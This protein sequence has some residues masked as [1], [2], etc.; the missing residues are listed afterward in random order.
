MVKN[1]RTVITSGVFDL[2][3]PGHI[4]LLKFAKKLAGK[5]GRLIVVIARDE[6][7]LRR[8]RRKPILSENDRLKIVNSIK[9][10]DKAVL[11][12][13]PMS[14]KKIIEKYRP[15]VVVFGYDQKSIMNAFQKEATTKKWKIKIVKAP[16]LLSRRR[17]S[18]T[19]LINK[20]KNIHLSER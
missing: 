2:I 17:Y 16:K 8:K 3:H 15:D 11:G 5:D 18:T 14:F 7:V 9:Y 13:N 10:V 12:F 1:P 20:A 6:T 19:Q 4:F